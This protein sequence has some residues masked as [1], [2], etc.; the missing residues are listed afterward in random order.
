[1]PLTPNQSLRQL[2]RL[3]GHL[4][5]SENGSRDKILGGCAH[6]KQYSFQTLSLTHLI[7]CLII[8]E[9]MP[10]CACVRGCDFD[11]IFPIS[12][13]SRRLFQKIIFPPLLVAILNF[14]VKSKNAFISETQE[15]RA[16]ST[17]F[18]TRRV[19]AESINDFPQKS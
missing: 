13:L 3:K 5:V 19:S 1:M 11:E 14:C 9:M 7:C 12:R 6:F 4:K 10:V 2:K 16:I 17:K 8:Y 15:D 18:L